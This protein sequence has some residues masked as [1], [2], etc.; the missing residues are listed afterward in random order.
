MKKLASR[1]FWITIVVAAY[2]ALMA[3]R[4]QGVDNTIGTIVCTACTIVVVIGYMI[5]E[6]KLDAENIE[7]TA[8]EDND[9][10][11]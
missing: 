5:I 4:E 10:E 2:F 6:G 8:D 11:E 3:L 9:E 7:I 1:K